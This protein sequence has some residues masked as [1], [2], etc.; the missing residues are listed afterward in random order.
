VRRTQTAT[1]LERLER[2]YAR[3]TGRP[4]RQETRSLLLDSY[5]RAERTGRRLTLAFAAVG[6]LLAVA[7]TRRVRR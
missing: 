2:D 4:L 6:A 5:R 1:A 7:M 3:I